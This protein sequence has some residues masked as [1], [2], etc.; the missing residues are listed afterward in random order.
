MLLPQPGFCPRPEWQPAPPR[1]RDLDRTLTALVSGRGFL[2]RT[3]L[4]IPEHARLRR[5]RRVSPRRPD[6][7]H[8]PPATAPPAYPSTSTLLRL[9]PGGAALAVRVAAAGEAGSRG[10]FACPSVS[11]AASTSRE[12]K[13]IIV[14]VSVPRFDRR[15]VR[16]NVVAR[17]SGNL[18]GPSA[19]CLVPGICPKRALAFAIGFEVHTRRPHL[20]GGPGRESNDESAKH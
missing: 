16:P 18:R 20:C 11:A 14:P 9:R 5:D 1:A 19:S 8:R 7:L 6:P 13:V 2:S 10:P 17:P 4:T 12:R 15:V 3:W